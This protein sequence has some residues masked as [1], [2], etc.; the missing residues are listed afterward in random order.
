MQLK[1]AN[2][3]NLYVQLL[4]HQFHTQCVVSLKPRKRSIEAPTNL[5]HSSCIHA[6]EYYYTY[7]YVLFIIL[8]T[9]IMSRGI[10]CPYPWL[11]LIICVNCYSYCSNSCVTS[12]LSTSVCVCIW[13]TSKYTRNYSLLNGIHMSKHYMHPL[14]CWVKSFYGSLILAFVQS[15]LLHYW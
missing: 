8:F 11:Y 1:Y 10:G 3:S 7:T 2:T 15:E 6:T 12:F 5:Q 14:W 4:S 13:T 9:L